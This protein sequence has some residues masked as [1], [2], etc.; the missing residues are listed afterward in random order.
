MLRAILSAIVI[1]ALLIITLAVGIIAGGARDDVRLSTADRV[2]ASAEAIKLSNDLAQERFAQASS[3]ASRIAEIVMGL[4]CPRSGAEL[5]A[6]SEPVIDP[7]TGQPQIGPNGRPVLRGAGLSCPTPQHDMVLGA[8][9]RWADNLGEDAPDLVIVA[10]RNGEVVARTGPTMRDWYGENK[11]N[12]SSFPVVGRTEEFGTQRDVIVWRDH[13]TAPTA[14]ALVAASPVFRE[15]SAG[16]PEFLGSVL[17]GDFVNNLKAESDQY[18]VSRSDIV[19]FAIEDGS[20]LFPGSTLEGDAAF[21]D[22]L[23]VKSYEE[24]SLTDGGVSTTTL[25]FNGLINEG[26]GRAFRFESGGDDY[27]LMPGRFNSESAT[28]AGP[29]GF[30]VLTSL[31]EALAPVNKF[32]AV[33]IIALVLALISIFIVI[34]AV[35]LFLKPADDISRGVQEVIAG[36][37]NYMWPVDKKS[38]FTDLAHSLNIMSARLQGKPD[39]DSEDAAG[40]REWQGMVGGPSKASAAP[41]GGG[42]PVAGLGNL[43]GRSSQHTDDE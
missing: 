31:T 25:D 4:R 35:R 2:Q 29:A 27:Y 10:D 22:S 33:G 30:L 11:P 40:A 1:V 5:R 19:Y 18:S 8:I 9:Q 20:P 41:K 14:V 43:R 16:A 13:E 32:K 23:A 34:V 38:Y 42:K 21:V 6:L 17:M 26:S 36:N 39:P 37:K 24:V 28:E 7:A 3:D 15:R 12:M